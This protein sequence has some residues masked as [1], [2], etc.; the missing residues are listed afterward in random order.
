MP[1]SKTS[2]EAF[3]RILAVLRDRWSRHLDTTT[4]EQAREALGLP[5]DDGQRWRLYEHLRAEPGPLTTKT[6][7]GVSA[8]TV[9]LTNEEKLAGRALVLGRSQDEA[10]ACAGLDASAWERA[11]TMLRRVGLLSIEGW[12]PADGH[13]RLLEGVGLFFHTVRA[14]G[15]VFN[16][17]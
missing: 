12:R 13:E 1:E 10:R 15:E 11:K 4:T 17:P 8:A 9:T 7:Y 14:R 5:L 16:V 2:N 3:E 6:H